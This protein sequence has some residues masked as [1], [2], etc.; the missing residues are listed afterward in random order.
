MAELPSRFPPTLS[1]N[2]QPLDPEVP[3]VSGSS[4]GLWTRLLWTHPW[5]PSAFLLLIRH[6]L[7]TS[8]HTCPLQ[9]FLP[10]VG[11]QGPLTRTCLCHEPVPRLRARC[12]RLNGGVGSWWDCPEVEQWAASPLHFPELEIARTR[13]CGCIALL[14]G[15]TRAERRRSPLP[16][17]RPGRQPSVWQAL[18]RQPLSQRRFRN[19]CCV[20]LLWFPEQQTRA[21]CPSGSFPSL[22]TSPAHPSTTLAAP[23]HTACPQIARACLSGWEPWQKWGASWI[24]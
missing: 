4:L 1:A 21:S 22:P 11:W 5:V 18:L 14:P 23:L 19:R 16:P 8:D 3:R 24:A 20:G 12:T 6:F 2:S 9:V 15:T 17:H 7:L 13:A 10:G